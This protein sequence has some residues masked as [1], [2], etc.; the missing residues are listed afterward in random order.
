M[1]DQ[2]Q[3]QQAT[4]PAGEEH[5]TPTAPRQWQRQRQVTQR[6]A[7]QAQAW[8]DRYQASDLRS[9]IYQRRHARTLGLIDQLNLPPA[10]PALEV[11]PGAGY[12][13]VALARRGLTVT[14][15]DATPTLLELTR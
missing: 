13:T 4:P 10:S 8:Q 15:L 3:H 2:H 14:A 11:G 9:R 6:F 7:A 1:R 5:P 12:T